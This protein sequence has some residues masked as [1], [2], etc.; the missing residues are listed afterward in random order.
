MITV[1]LAPPIV[2]MQPRAPLGDG[3]EERRS[4][5]V[6]NDI[7]LF[8]A[9]PMEMRCFLANLPLGVVPHELMVL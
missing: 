2:A 5:I 7:Y 6:G 9:G 1:V 8:S 4:V 3:S